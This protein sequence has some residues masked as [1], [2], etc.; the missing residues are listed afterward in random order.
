MVLNVSYFKNQSAHGSTVG[1]GND[2]I[3]I[4][5]LHMPSDCN[6]SYTYLATP[7]LA[8]RYFLSILDA[9]FLLSVNQFFTL[10]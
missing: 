8:K 5:C 9:S 1:L 7:K 3:Y 2:F 4:S 6:N 10:H